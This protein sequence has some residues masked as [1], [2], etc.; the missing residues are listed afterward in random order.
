[1]TVDADMTVF[2]NLDQEEKFIDRL[3]A[4]FEGRDSNTRGFALRARGAAD[5][6]KRRAARRGVGSIRF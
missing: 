2:T 1:M 5:A 4:H 3:L 6:S